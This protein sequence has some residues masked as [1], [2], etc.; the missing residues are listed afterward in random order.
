MIVMNKEI[1]EK[2]QNLIGAYSCCKE[3]EGCG[4]RI[5]LAIGTD[6]EK[7]QAKK[8]VAEL[9]EDIMPIDGLISFSASDMGAKVFGAGKAKEVFAHAE[10]IRP[11]ARNIAT[12][13]PVRP[14]KRFLAI[15]TN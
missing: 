13:P 14:V 8:L 12:V 4:E 2:V 6:E 1:I 15:R 10:A 9:E 5:S 7:T 3:G 11:Q